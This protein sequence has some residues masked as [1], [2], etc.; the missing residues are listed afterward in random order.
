MYLFVAFYVNC[1]LFIK[2]DTDQSVDV[3]ILQ[4]KDMN[5]NQTIV[6]CMLLNVSIFVSFKFHCCPKS[7]E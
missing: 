3:N 2:L 7:D 1:V 4:M 6:A 5:M